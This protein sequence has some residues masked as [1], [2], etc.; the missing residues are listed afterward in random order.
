MTI[1]E[2]LRLGSCRPIRGC[3]GRWILSGNDS[4]DPGKLV[5]R[6]AEPRR[7]RRASVPDE[8]W[9]CGLEDGGLI[10]Y[11]KPDGRFVHTVCDPEGFRRKLE[12]LDVSREDFRSGRMAWLP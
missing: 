6:D 4:I 8:I 2:I 5:G 10:S 9:V 7:F 12:K 1:A 3:P 11:R